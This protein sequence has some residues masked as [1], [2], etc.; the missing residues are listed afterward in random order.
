MQPLATSQVL[1]SGGS[2]KGQTKRD[3]DDNDE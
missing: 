1:A 3:G 2:K